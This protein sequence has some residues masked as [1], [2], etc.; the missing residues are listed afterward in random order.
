VTESPDDPLFV[1]AINEVSQGLN[2]KTVAECVEDA[3][4]LSTLRKLG[5]DYVQG[6]LIGHPM[7]RLHDIFW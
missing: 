3:Q 2:I 6:F 4:T 5:V 1:K 7:Q